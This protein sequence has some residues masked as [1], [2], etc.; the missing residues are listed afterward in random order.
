MESYSG[1]CQ[2]PGDIGEIVSI[3]SSMS[4]VVFTCFHVCLFKHRGG[5]RG[6]GSKHHQS[7]KQYIIVCIY[8]TIYIYRN[9][10][11]FISSFDSQNTQSDWALST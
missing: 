3:F 4:P 7:P 2:L 5:S 8:I 10:M 11:K 1:V 6:S 9:S